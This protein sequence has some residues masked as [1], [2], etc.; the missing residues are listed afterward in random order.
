MEAQLI[1]AG[2]R[3]ESHYLYKHESHGDLYRSD[4]NGR[5]YRRRRGHADELMGRTLS[6]A[7]TKALAITPTLF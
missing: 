1:A 5:W 6:A 3:K 2:W 7:I 4:K